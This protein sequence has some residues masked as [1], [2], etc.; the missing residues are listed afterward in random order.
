MAAKLIQTTRCPRSSLPRL[1]VVFS[2]SSPSHTP[3]WLPHSLRG[4]RLPLAYCDW[5]KA[6]VFEVISPSYISPIKMLRGAG[7]NLESTSVPS[8]VSPDM[9]LFLTLLLLSFPTFSILDKCAS[10]KLK[11]KI[12]RCARALNLFSPGT[13]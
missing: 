2:S 13:V 6:K 11:L 5:R 1:L 12:G 10:C 8:N 3:T 9:S 4:A 7:I